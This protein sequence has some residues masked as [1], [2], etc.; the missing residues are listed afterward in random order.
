MFD[1]AATRRVARTVCPSR[2]ALLVGTAGDNTTALGSPR[3]LRET[4]RVWSVRESARAERLQ[5][6]DLLDELTAE[7]WLAPSL[8]DG[9]RVCDVVAH[10]I[11]YLDQSRFGLAFEMARVRG[12]VDRLNERALDD[13]PR[14]DPKTLAT[15]MRLAAEPAGAGALYGCR[16]ALIECMIHQQDVRRPLGFSRLI[17]NRRLTA[18]LQFAWWSPVIGGARRMRGVRA[19]AND[20]GWSAGRGEDVTGSGEAL[21]LAMTGRVAAVVDDLTGPG[22]D[23]LVQSIR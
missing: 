22:V 9:W 23:R 13:F 5:F 2:T 4:E 7:Q 8:C 21:L 1:H 18:A 12:D 16:V 10:T 17:P 11:A 14:D 15:T 20:V 19:V 3:V 6:A